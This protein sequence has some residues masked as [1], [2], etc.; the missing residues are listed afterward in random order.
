MTAYSL[1]NLSWSSQ[2]TVKEWILF[3][4]IL[5]CWVVFFFFNTAPPSYWL[6]PKKSTRLASFDDSL[7]LGRALKERR[8]ERRGR[9]A[10][11]EEFCWGLGT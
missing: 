1:G 11:A 8:Q 3:L 6:S 2:V 9:W 5:C 4:I 10:F 7:S